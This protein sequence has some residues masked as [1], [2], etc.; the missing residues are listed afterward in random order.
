M[1]GFIISAI[2]LCLVI[3]ANAQQPRR[4]K[5]AQPQ[6]KPNAATKPAQRGNT[7]SGR[8][9]DDGGRPVEGAMVMVAP[10]GTHL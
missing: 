7:L 9:I 2:L 4:N 5:P 6:A 1:K 10:A 3:A 8:V